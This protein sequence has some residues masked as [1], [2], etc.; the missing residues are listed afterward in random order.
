LE[1]PICGAEACCTSAEF[2]QCIVDG[3]PD[4]HPSILAVLQGRLFADWDCEIGTVCFVPRPTIKGNGSFD[5][6][7]AGIVNWVLIPSPPG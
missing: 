2:P 4:Y 7:E 6:L 5:T 3:F 1:T